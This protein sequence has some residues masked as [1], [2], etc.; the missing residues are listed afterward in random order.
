MSEANSDVENEENDSETKLK[1]N[2]KGG[3]I[4]VV[5]RKNADSECTIAADGG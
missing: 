2:F 1:S 5:C 4:A 3:A